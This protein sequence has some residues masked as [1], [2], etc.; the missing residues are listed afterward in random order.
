MKEIFVTII[1][2]FAS[3]IIFSII[4]INLKDEFVYNLSDNSKNKVQIQVIDFIMYAST[5]QSGVGLTDIMPNTFVSKL[6]TIIQQ[7]I[8]ISSYLLV[9]YFF[10][11]SKK[12]R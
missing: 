5:I 6:I 1:F 8:M 12:I 11:N 10:L 4:Y 9:V 2:N 3:I 7:Y